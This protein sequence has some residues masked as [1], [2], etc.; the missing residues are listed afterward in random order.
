[1]LPEY[2]E[3]HNPVKIVSGKKALES[4]PGIL[5]EHSVRNPMIV[6]GPHISKSKMMLK[7]NSALK[8]GKI[9]ADN[10][11]SD[12]PQDSSFDTVKAA[13]AFFERHACDSIVA[14]G[15]GSVIDTAKAAN[16]LISEKTDDLRKFA[17]LNSL[18]TPQKPLIVVPTTVGSGSEVTAT[19]VVYDPEKKVKT[20]FSSPLM[21]PVAA[22]L[23]PRMTE[24]LPQ[25]L[26]ASTAMDALTHAVESYTCVQKNPI[27]DM[28]AYAAVNLIR[29]NLIPALKNE[30]EKE[31]VFALANASL[32]AGIAINNSAVGAVHAL[33]HACG[34]VAHIPHGTAMGLLLPAVMEYNV[35]RVEEYY[36]ELLL[37]FAG[38]DLFAQTPFNIRATRLINEVRKLQKTLNELCGFPLSLKDAGVQTS[39]L[40]EIAKLAVNDPTMMINPRDMSIEEAE[41][42]L[43]K[44]F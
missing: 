33:G 26:I 10:I 3:F 27:S 1:M 34:S 16:I 44:V 21:H 5:F 41:K 35:R 14:I 2:Y 25:K 17:G 18:K 12:I 19:A 9:S 6:T 28:Y 37:P 23:D 40:K 31:E 32:F 11:F 13:S 8:A 7:V 29:R 4:I 43:L 15:G 42:L 39:Q 36:G 30:G 38:D 20:V 22:V 24:T